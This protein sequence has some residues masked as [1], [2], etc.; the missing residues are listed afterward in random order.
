MSAHPRASDSTTT[1]SLAPAALLISVA[2]VAFAAFAYPMYV[3]RPFRQQ[4]ERELAAALAVF[5]WAPLITL[6]CALLAIITFL[7]A[8]RA[9]GAQKR[10]ALWIKRVGVGAALVLTLLFAVAARVNIFEKMFH[11]VGRAQF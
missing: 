8:M 2:L 3:I 10:W 5:R 1:T 7:P 11:P 4:G 9:L 6:L